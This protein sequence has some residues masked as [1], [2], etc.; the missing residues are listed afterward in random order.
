M[1]DAKGII[2][3]IGGDTSNLEKALKKVNSSSSKLGGELISINRLLKLDPKNTELLSQKQAVLS[4]KINKTAEKLKKLESIQDQVK[5]KWEK[6]K[7]VETQLTNLN[8]KIDKTSS[9]LEKLKEE[10]EKA[11]ESFKE[12]KIS[13]EQYDNINKSV[14]NCKKTLSELKKEQKELSKDTVSTENYRAYR[15]DIE[16]TR[17]ELNKLLLEDE[18]NL[19]G[20][21]IEEY[22]DKFVKVG[23]KMENIGNKLTKTLTTSVLAFGTVSAKSAIDFETAFTGVEKTVDGTTEQ[24]ENLKKGIKNMSKEI[25]STTTE[26]SAVAEAAGQLGIKTDDILSFTRVMIDLG[27]STN[28]SADEAATALAKFANVTNMSSNNYDKLGST[29]VAL[30]NNFATT[31]RDIVEMGTRLA[32]TGELTGLTESQIMALATAMSSVGLEAEAGSS[33]MSKLLK[34][35]QVSVETGNNKLQTFA[36]VSNMSVSDFKKAFEEDA[37]KALS[38]FLKGLNDTERNG[39]SA[40]SILNDMGMTETRLS[41]TVLSLANSSDLLNNAVDIGNNAWKENNALTNE[42]SKRYQTTASKLKTTLNRL[43][44]VGTNLGD[45]LL[46]TVNKF[47]D[48]IDKWVDKLDD[49]DDATLE[50][51]I[52][53]GLFV[54]ATGPAIKIVGQ[55]TT[56]VG[57]V[58]KTFGQFS[59]AIDVVNTGVKSTNTTVNKLAS[60]LNK[61]ISP[62]GLVTVGIGALVLAYNSATKKAKE[63]TQQINELTDAFNNEIDARTSVINSANEQMQSNLTEISNIQRLK[64]ELSG[65]VDENGRVKDGYEARVSFILNELNN[66]LGTEYSMIGNIIENYKNLSNSIDELIAKKRAQIVLEAD[67]KKFSEAINNKTAA[68]KT[69]LELQDKI[70]S[71]EKEIADFEKMHRYG[72]D[73]ADASNYKELQKQLESLKTSLAN[74]EQEIDSYNSAITRYEKNSE[75]IIQGGL[76]NYQKVYD[77][78]VEIETNTTDI[79][80]KEI[81]KRIET[82]QDSVTKTTRLYNLEAEKN[83]EAKNNIYST[84][85]EESKKNLQLA[86][87][88]LIAM[89]STT[90][91]MSPEVVKAWNDLAKNSRAEYNNAISKLPQDMQDRINNITGVVRNDASVKEALSFLGDEAIKGFDKTNEAEEAGQNLLKGSLNGV[92][93]RTLRQQIIS[94]MYNLGTE[95]LNAII[96]KAWDEHSPSKKSEKGAVNLLKG[97]TKGIDKEK[98][99]TIEKMLSFGNNLMNRFNSVMS[100]DFNSFQRMPNLQSSISQTINTQLKPKILSPTIN[101]TTQNLDNTEMNRIIDTLNRRLGMQW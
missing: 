21:K 15:R 87:D 97:I 14:A 70:A 60:G 91:T 5:K 7:E 77:S 85:L 88:D 31:E 34:Q 56:G 25:P 57:K 44:D 19:A 96:H 13:Q 16:R 66:A 67:E 76:E 89:T 49:L 75:L 12:G 93:N 6:Y 80:G 41:N 101:I 3:E 40:I 92:N 23:S 18:W 42:A 63:Q 27:N 68:Q 30:G 20:K 53:I 52:K 59:Q 54:A 95:G 39:K 84:N 45:K 43:Q 81:N 28:L 51:I 73:F 10:Q 69:Y 90:Q 86:I 36:K 46:P 38:A 47:I 99:N 11:T 64:E 83:Q 55:L 9:T 35:I 22:G 8:K 2:V 33:A 37:V 65:L 4:D 71:K 82:L 79:Q 26:I 58:I 78:V 48:K 62:V 98:S 61:L 24:L 50:N 72:M 100:L 32:A 17:V 1:G 29:I 94:S 74:S